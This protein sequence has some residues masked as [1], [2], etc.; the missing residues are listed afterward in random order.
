MALY[1]Q[2]KGEIMAKKR[3]Q[4]KIHKPQAT[5]NLAKDVTTPKFKNIPVPPL[6]KAEISRL[7]GILD[8]YIAGTVA[9]MKIEGP[10]GFDLRTK[11][12]QVPDGD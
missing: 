2:F 8:N 1:K 5:Q 3:P 11:C 7:S 12:V 9:G 6:A 10:W 4:L